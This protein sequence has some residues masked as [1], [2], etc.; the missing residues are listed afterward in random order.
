VTSIFYD[1]KSVYEYTYL[2][3][4]L[5]DISYNGPLPDVLT[6]LCTLIILM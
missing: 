4:R 2:H 3:L 5:G 1:N 6:A